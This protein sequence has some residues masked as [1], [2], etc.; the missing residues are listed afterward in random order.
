[1]NSSVDHEEN[2]IEVQNVSFSYSGHVV[3]KDI[4]LSIHRGDYIGLIGG[5]GSGKTTLIKIIL[6]LLKPDSG[7]VKLFGKNI[8]DFKERSKIGY[9]PQ[10]ATNF[11]A[12]FPATVQEVVLMGRYGKRGLFNRVTADD[13]EKAKEALEHVE[14][15]QYRDRLIGDLSGGQ[16]Q[17][18]FIAR[19]LATEPEVIFLDEPTVGVEQNIK[20]DFYALIRKLNRDLHLTVVLVTHDVESIAQEAMHVACLD[21]T[22]FFHD[23]V[24]AYFKDTHKIIHPHP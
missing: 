7:T 2:I 13:R 21:C 5:N 23:S 1:M 20:D 10:K 12:S 15:W 18:V 6:G 19:A 22:I 11:D 14:M 4:N 8:E 3:L 24:D 17:R 16:Q 9:V